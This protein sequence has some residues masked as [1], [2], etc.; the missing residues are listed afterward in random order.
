VNGLRRIFTG[1]SPNDTE[2]CT[3]AENSQ[4]WRGWSGDP[5]VPWVSRETGLPWIGDGCSLRIWDDTPAW[6]GGF[7]GYAFYV[8]NS[9][10]HPMGV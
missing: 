10:G 2:D 4:D 8:R 3:E 5:E 9:G 1:S 6:Y 7:E